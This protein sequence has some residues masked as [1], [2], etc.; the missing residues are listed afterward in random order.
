MLSPLLTLTSG[1]LR[2]GLTLFE[3][4]PRLGAFDA[5]LAAAAARSGAAALI[6]ADTAFADL[7]DISHV[8]PDSSGV[9]RVLADA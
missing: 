4:V 8:I 7:P 3:T 6:S 9:A 2:R 1:H 5:V